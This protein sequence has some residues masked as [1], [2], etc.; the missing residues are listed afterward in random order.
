MADEAAKDQKIF[1]CDLSTLIE[2]AE[3]DEHIN[4]AVKLMQ[5]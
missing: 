1:S 2:L 4:L 5:R 3:T